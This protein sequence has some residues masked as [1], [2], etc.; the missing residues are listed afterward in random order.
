M[1][2]GQPTDPENGIPDRSRQEVQ[3]GSGGLQQSYLF[4]VRSPQY[5]CCVAQKLEKPP[6]K[7]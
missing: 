4:V 7:V 6:M 1:A 2:L 5:E 3:T